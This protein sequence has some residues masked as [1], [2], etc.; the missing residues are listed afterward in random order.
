MTMMK[1]KFCC[2]A[3]RGLYED[4]YS[5]QAGNG[6]I[7]VYHGARSQRG[8]GLGSI[9][10]GFFRS[11]L[12]MLRR[13]LSFFGREALRTG[14]QIAGDVAD[15]QPVLDS[16][17]RRVSNRINSYVPGLIPQ[18]GS[19]RGRKRTYSQR[20]HYNHDNNNK[21]HNKKKRRGRATKKRKVQ[22]GNGIFN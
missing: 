15:G 10:S 9:L 17:K 4:Y 19:G 11:A 2:E 8:H 1:H 6:G 5:R 12:P 21:T 3:S 16:A 7:P 22:F 14:A 18:S 13:G 20:K